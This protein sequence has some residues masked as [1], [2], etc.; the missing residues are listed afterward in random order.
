MAFNVNKMIHEGLRFGVA[1][2]SDFE[3]RINPPEKLAR[4]TEM[5][6]ELSFRADTVEIPGRTAM[7]IDHR[8]SNNG[9][10]NKVP[11]AQLYPDVTI[12]FLLSDDLGEKKYMELWQSKMLDTTPSNGVAAGQLYK[13]TGF[14][15]KYFDDYKSTI[16]IKQYDRTGLEQNEIILIDAYPII[17]NGI[18]MGW[19]DDSIA[20][21][22]VQF[23]LRYYEIKSPVVTRVG[24]GDS[25]FVQ[26]EKERSES[27]RKEI[28]GFTGTLGIE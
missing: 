23:A 27:P 2:T 11:Y 18:Q 25:N 16:N 17:I 12:T 20:K 1:K 3:V 4:V 5:T 24:V 8:F 15:V 26:Q 9:P 10:I 19:G 28:E 22:S 7:T 6:R 14:N 21:L 13:H